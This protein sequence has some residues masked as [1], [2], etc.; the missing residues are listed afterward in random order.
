MASIGC[1]SLLN[2]PATAGGVVESDATII[3]PAR[4]NDPATEQS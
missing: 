3:Y 2:L 4:L 1:L